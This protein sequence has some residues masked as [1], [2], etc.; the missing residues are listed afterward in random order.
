MKSLV[1][2]CILSA[3]EINSDEQVLDAGQKVKK[4]VYTGEPVIVEH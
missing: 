4:S 3:M 1:Y 2:E